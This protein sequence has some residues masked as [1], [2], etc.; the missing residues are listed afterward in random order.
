MR[1]GT[2]MSPDWQGAHWSCSHGRVGLCYTSMPFAS[3]RPTKCVIVCLACFMCIYS[4]WNHCTK[5]SY[6]SVHKHINVCVIKILLNKNGHCLKHKM[7]EHSWFSF[8]FCIKDWLS[9]VRFLFH[10][11]LTGNGFFFFSFTLLIASY[12]CPLSSIL[13]IFSHFLWVNQDWVRDMW[14]SS[15][16][17]CSVIKMSEH[18][19]THMHS[20][21]KIHKPRLGTI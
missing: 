6:S 5:L 8:I 7:K 17:L 16:H 4:Q 3:Q 15:D 9:A 19:R 13:G 2:F 1:G 18:A 20:C 11:A 10:V 21:L 12:F 14:L